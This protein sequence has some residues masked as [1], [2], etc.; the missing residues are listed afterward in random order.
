MP[1]RKFSAYSGLLQLAKLVAAELRHGGMGPGLQTFRAML[2]GERD[3]VLD[4]LDLLSAEAGRKRQNVELCNALIILFGLALNEARMALESNP[5]GAEVHLIYQVKRRLVEAIEQ[6][7]VPPEFVMALA[8]QFADAKLDPGDDMRAAFEAVSMSME[9]DQDVGPEAIGEQFA[10][11]AD[12]YGHD[13]LLIHEEL[14]GQLAAFPE[15]HRAV[16][17][18]TFLTSEV[19]AMREAALG[20]LLDPNRAL[21]KQQAQGL[22]AAAQHGKLSAESAERLV[23]MRPWLEDDV[24]ELLD[25]AVRAGRQRNLAP[26]KKPAVQI[27]GMFASGCDGSGAQSVFVN[28]KRGRKLA[29]ASLLVKQGFGVRDTWLREDLSRGELNLLL[30]EIA[31]SMDLFEASPEIVQVIIA[32]RLAEHCARAEPPPF[33]LVQ[34][35]EAVGLGQIR[36]ERLTTQ[37]LIDQV[38]GGV[39]PERQSPKAIAEALARSKSWPETYAFVQSWYEPGEEAAIRGAGRAR[40]QREEAV[41]QTILP[42]KRARWADLLAWT[43]KAAQD[44]TE[45]DAAIDFALVARELLGERALTEIPIARWIAEMTVAALSQR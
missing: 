8:Q 42:A 16:I 28:L 34:F 30:A 38:L 6:G 35:I 29:F 22:A 26:A 13:P 39:P 1:A 3:I 37:S 43:A 11:L 31:S 5:A 12:A 19:A 36:P 9:E 21:A 40:K 14:S 32:H 2:L 23:L 17:V 7:G 20:W 24:Q 4:I 33:G 44:E 45:G 27:A 18:G 41:L 15:A 25:K 10:A